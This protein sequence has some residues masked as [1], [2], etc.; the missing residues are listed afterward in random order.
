[1][2]NDEELR[3][4]SL[5]EVMEEYI[6]LR[7]SI[8][9]SVIKYKCDKQDLAFDFKIDDLAPF[10]L[11]CP[12]LEIPIDYFKKGHGGSNYS[13][14]IDRVIPD[15]GYV[16][17]NVRIISQ[18]ANRLKQNSSIDEQIQLLA[19]SS[20]TDPIEIEEVIKKESL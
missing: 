11:V 9:Y 18:K 12:V 20:N 3:H 5:A 19:Y 4:L 10:P 14:S 15:D 2:F 7:L 13:P 8:T 16:R 6:R 17:G 1:M